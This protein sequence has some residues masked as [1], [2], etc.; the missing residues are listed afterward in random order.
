LDIYTTTRG[1]LAGKVVDVLDE[2][3]DKICSV[4]T[5]YITAK[6]SFKGKIDGKKPKD[7]KIDAILHAF[8][9]LQELSNAENLDVDEA[10]TLKMRD[11][12][13]SESDDEQMAYP[14]EI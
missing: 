11:E 14:D 2:Q 9:L 7:Q 10:Q 6:T 12:S 3:I 4:D 1:D 8:K 5:S 13:E